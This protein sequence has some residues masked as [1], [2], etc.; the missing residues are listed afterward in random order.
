MPTKRNQPPSAQNTQ[1]QRSFCGF[2]EF[3][4][5]LYQTDTHS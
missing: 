4:G 5:Y 2:C 1:N 3:R